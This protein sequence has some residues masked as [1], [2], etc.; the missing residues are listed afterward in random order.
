MKRISI[1]GVSRGHEYSPNHVGNDA[2]IFNKVVDEL[3]R[4]GCEVQTY[5][6]K[7]FVSQ[8][9]CADVIFDMARDVNTLAR[10]KEL[11][12]AGCVVINSAYGIENCVRK[13]MTET[14]LAHH[15]PHPSSVIVP[16]DRKYSGELLPCWIKRAD[17]HAIVKADVSYAETREEVD[18]ILADFHERGIAEAVVNLHLEGD[19]I[20]FYGVKDTGFFHWFYPGKDSHT[21]FGLEE[22]NGEAKGIPFDAESLIEC[23][24]KASE[25]LDVPVYGGDCVVQSDGSIKII[26]F[27]D[28]PSFA[29]CREEAAPHIAGYIYKMMEIKV[30]KSQNYE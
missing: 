28:W 19:L 16:T 7:E 9:V 21:K 23:A 22:I 24:N 27:N 25:A 14:L 12:D 15:V 3:R 5:T 4:L 30:D 20:K 8:E 1:A 6:E 2:A 10:L 18:N 17:S 11:E 13:P 29:C 26:D